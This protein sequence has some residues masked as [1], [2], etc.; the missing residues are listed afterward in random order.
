MILEIKDASFSYHK[1]KEILTDVN[2]TLD[3]AK[4]VSILGPN[5][6][7]KTTLLKCMIGLLKWKKGASYLESKDIETLKAKE[8]WS[9]ISYIPQIHS[10]SFAYTGLEMVL[11]GLNIQIGYFSKPSKKDI[12]KARKLMKEIGI[13]HLE[14]KDCNEMSGG[15]LQMVLI[16]RALI[17]DPKIIVLDE[18]ETGLDFHNQLLVLNLIKDLV[19][20]NK[21]SAVMNTHYP[22]NALMISDYALIMSKDGRSIYGDTKEVITP[23]NI[24]NIFKVEVL[25]NESEHKGRTFKSIIP[26]DLA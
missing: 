11:L 5:G 13:S 6:V 1:D 25:M 23:E 7:G 4:I 20:E 18:P 8:I 14:D 21:I 3:E 24:E 22:S 16:A 9:K 19:K 10:F 26:V 12:L 17:S 2:F 15:E